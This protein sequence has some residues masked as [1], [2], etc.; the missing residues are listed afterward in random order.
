MI[1]IGQLGDHPPQPV[2]DP[3]VQYPIYPITYILPILS[4]SALIL[5]IPPL[6]WHVRNR[7]IGASSMI[8]WLSIVNLI[9]IINPI[10]W[11]RDDIMN[12]WKGYGLCDIEIHIQIATTVAF[13]GA[14]M[15]IIRNLAAVLDTKEPSLPNRTQRRIKQ[16]LDLFLCFGFPALIMIVYYVVQANR[17]TIFTTTGCTWWIERTWVSIILVLIWPLVLAIINAYLASKFEQ[18]QTIS[19][20]LIWYSHRLMASLQVPERN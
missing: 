1:D 17:Y 20:M 9:Y 19:N 16:G 11:P 13:P 6:I 3:N 18:F 8:A 5:Q 4:F 10:I 15:V 14:T 12:W 7:N 2:M